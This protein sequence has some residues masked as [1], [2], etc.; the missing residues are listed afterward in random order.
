M[1]ITIICDYTSSPP[2]YSGGSADIFR[3]EH[4]GHPVAIKSLRIYSF[5]NFEA[6]ATVSASVFV[7]RS[8]F[9]S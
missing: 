3:A 5:S 9:C 6:I 4:G 8:D 2:I 7:F 1:H